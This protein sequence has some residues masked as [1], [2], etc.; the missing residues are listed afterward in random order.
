MENGTPQGSV[1]SPLQFPIMVANVFSEIRS[2]KG[3]SPL[4]DG[5]TMWK[6][7]RKVLHII[8]KKQESINTV[9]HCQW[10]FKFSV[11]KKLI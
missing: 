6:R 2:D 8:R 1:I 11:G 3:R 4:A 10:C 5:E 7:D 9:E